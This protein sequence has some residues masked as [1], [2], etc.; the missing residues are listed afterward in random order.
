MKLLWPILYL[1][2]ALAFTIDHSHSK[3]LELPFVPS[4]NDL[5]Y[6]VT[7]SFS[8]KFSF[9][10]GDLYANDH[11]FYPPPMTP[12]LQVPLYEGENQEKPHKT[13]ELAYTLKSQTT[14]TNKMPTAPDTTHVRVEF[15]DLQGNLV[16]PHAVAINL[17]VDQDGKYKSASFRVEPAHTGHRD[18][19][20]SQETQPWVIKYWDGRLDAIKTT[21]P[22]SDNENS[23]DMNRDIVIHTLLGIA[24]GLV[25]CSAVFLIGYLGRC[26]WAR[27]QGQKEL[28][29]RSQ[30]ISEKGTVYEKIP[31][32]SEVY[33]TD[34]SE[35]D[36]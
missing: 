25:G 32:I 31:I 19:H 36:V 2:S 20:L 18:N 4:P 14:H 13:V 8:I 1:G 6:E 23:M 7:S 27:V 30:I 3:I 5:I 26:L 29:R 9:Q 34:D 10:N 35:L 28:G 33:A 12:T 11:Q 24:T 15:L 16:S 22:S 21:V 17:Y